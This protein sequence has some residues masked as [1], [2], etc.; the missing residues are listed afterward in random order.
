MISLFSHFP[1]MKRCN[2][3]GTGEQGFPF[4][5]NMHEDT[6]AIKQEHAVFVSFVRENEDR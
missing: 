5:V 2:D 6:S 3:C 1:F 4:S